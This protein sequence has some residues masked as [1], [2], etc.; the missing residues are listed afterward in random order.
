MRATLATSGHPFQSAG[1]GVEVVGFCFEKGGE[2]GVGRY[3]L[4]AKPGGFEVIVVGGA[5]DD[6]EV[7]HGGPRI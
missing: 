5:G 3:G 4:L 6:V 1:V 2:R 7:V